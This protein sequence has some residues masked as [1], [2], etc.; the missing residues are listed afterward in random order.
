MRRTRGRSL[1]RLP[2]E[3][4][5]ERVLRGDPQPVVECAERQGGAHGAGQLKG[6]ENRFRSGS[7]RIDQCLLGHHGAVEGDAADVGPPDAVGS[8]LGQRPVTAGGQ[9]VLVDQEET[10]AT[11]AAPLVGAGEDAQEPTPRRVVDEPLLPVEPPSALGSTGGELSGEQVAAVVALGQGPGGHGTGAY[12]RGE[13]GRLGGA[14]RDLDGGGA[15]EGLAVCDRHRQVAAG[16]G[17]Q[18]LDEFDMVVQEAA[19]AGVDVVGGEAEVVELAAGFGGKPLLAVQGGHRAGAEDAVAGVGLSQEP[20]ESEHR[21]VRHGESPVVWLP[22]PGGARGTVR[23]PACPVVRAGRPVCGV[24][25]RWCV[26]D[27]GRAWR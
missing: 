11:G 6:L 15:E 14:A 22:G 27:A 16:H 9:P 24:V 13:T 18:E 23:D 1:S 12:V 20:V 7:G 19:V 21:A 26:P 3:V 17:A 25:T 4:A 5:A 10:E 8:H 2:V